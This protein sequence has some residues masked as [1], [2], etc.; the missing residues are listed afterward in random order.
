MAIGETRPPTAGR[1]PLVLIVDDEPGIRNA[2]E[3]YL[4]SIGYSVALASDGEQGLRLAETLWPAVILTDVRMPVMDGHVLLRRLNELGRN[5]SVVMMSGGGDID[6]A[7]GA[8][9]HG[10][11]DYLK[12][13][14]TPEELA[15]VVD[16]AR[17]LSEALDQM[18][19]TAR[20]ADL[21][22][23]HRLRAVEASVD[24]VVLVEHATER[25]TRERAIPPPPAAITDLKALDASSLRAAFPVQLPAL[26]ALSDRILR[27]TEARSLAMRGIAEAADEEL[28]LDARRCQHAGLLLDVGALYLLHEI[29]GALCQAGGPIADVP[30]MRAA[31]A[32]RHTLVGGLILEAWGIDAELVDLTHDHHATSL[33]SSTPALWCTA[34]L[35]GALAVHLTGFGDPLGDNGLTSDMLARCAYRLGV[36][37][38]TLRRLTQVLGTRGA[39]E[40]PPRPPLGSG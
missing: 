27:F 8:I 35:G 22:P 20:V 30:K 16:R 32:S 18:A 39:V 6:D 33:P 5:S 28:G 29:D 37:D 36:G 38:S 25:A 7:I 3:R 13:P 14:W 4:V 26:R 1:R 19:A 11:V 24:G 15:T 12:K 17:S 40:P 21:P 9:R 34:A 10:A 23:G 2:L 31:I